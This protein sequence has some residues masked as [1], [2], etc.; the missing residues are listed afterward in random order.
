MENKIA[1]LTDAAMTAIC[2]NQ[3]RER[4][5][6]YYDAQRDVMTP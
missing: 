1:G 2:Q 5:V 3:E 4:P 6:T